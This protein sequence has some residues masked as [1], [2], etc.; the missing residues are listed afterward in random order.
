MET[1]DI[2]P[3]DSAMKIG[4]LFQI[5]RG[6]ATGANGFFVIDQETIEK[7][8]IP[9]KFLKPLLPSPRYLASDIIEDDGNGD[10]DIERRRYLLDCDLLP[11]EVQSSYP[12]LWAY[13]LEGKSRGISD[14]YICSHRK[15]WYQQ[16]KRKPPLF[17]TT[18]MGRSSSKRK[19][20]F[21]FILNKSQT[22]ATNV[23][24]YLYPKPALKKMLDADSERINFFHKLLNNLD[25]KNLIQNGRTYGGGL[26]KM[27]PKE[28]ASLPLSNIPDWLHIEKETQT[29]F[30]LG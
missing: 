13:L 17:L 4:D 16:E 27:E 2:E 1:L 26:H 24:I 12:G 23:Y 19:N 14:C 25:P 20:P 9:R 3:D 29:A 10:P 21:R 7:Y 6:I 15:V 28:L 5:K 11:E 22:I 8:D 30:P 18:Y